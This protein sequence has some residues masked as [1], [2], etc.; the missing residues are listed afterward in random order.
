MLK[1]DFASKNFLEIN[2]VVIRTN[3]PSIINHMLPSYFLSLLSFAHE[4]VET[5]EHFREIHN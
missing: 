3:P 5:E 1:K 4:N 2:I